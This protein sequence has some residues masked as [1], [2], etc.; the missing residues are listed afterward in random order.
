MLAGGSV[1][2][3]GSQ[4]DF[5]KTDGGQE[6]AAS[7]LP[8]WGWTESRQGL[9]WLIC[10]EPDVTM[11][12]DIVLYWSNEGAWRVGRAAGSSSQLQGKER[13][14]YQCSTF[15]G[16]A[17]TVLGVS[18]R[19]VTAF[20]GHSIQRG[21]SSLLCPGR[22]WVFILPGS[23]QPG[24]GNT[25]E[26][27]N[28]RLTYLCW[29]PCLY[30]KS[31]VTCPCHIYLGVNETIIWQHAVNQVNSLSSG[32]APLG[33]NS[34]PQTP[35]PSFQHESMLVSYPHLRSKGISLQDEAQQMKDR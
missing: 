4:K 35:E 28:T 24:L 20:G 31:A 3:S 19:S 34:I 25:A 2:W 26:R 15:P 6:A 17:V 14:N 30:C 5:W 18:C 16:F 7:C 32:P 33:P 8:V 22:D 29:T 11:Y 21:S 27:L 13:Q 1:H 12:H 9:F 10:T 23:R